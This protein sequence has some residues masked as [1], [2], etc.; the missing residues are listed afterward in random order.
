M[1]NHHEETL[2]RR[3]FLKAVAATAAAASVVGGGA[4]VLLNQQEAGTVVT[5]LADSPPLPVVGAARTAVDV[6]T[7]AA[8]LLARLAS[9]QAENLR[10]QAEL[11][12]SQL[13]LQA[14][15]ATSGDV[16]ATNEALQ[17]ELASANERV[18]LL[19]GLVALYE[20]LENV[21][22]AETVD[23]GLDSV[24][25]ALDDL[26]GEVPTLEEGLAIGEQALADFE[27]EIPLVRQG[28]LWLEG[29]LG[30]L[31]TF[32]EKAESLLGAVVA[33]AESFLQK[34]NEWFQGILKWLPFG[35]GDTAAE[36]MDALAD[37]LDETPNTIQGL[38]RHVADPLDVWVG[39]NGDEAPVRS[40]LIK[41]L[42]EKA[43]DP[44]GNVVGKTY[45]ARSAF[46]DQLVPQYQL[47]RKN[48]QAVKE[49]I[50]AYRKQHEI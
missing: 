48:T 3:G 18:G 31:T 19:A 35:V 25:M 4:A 2:N 30:R 45:A 15:E 32:Y 34:L 10:L 49:Q 44:A 5:T 22:L 11:R 20:Q 9:A 23:Q 21:D 12:A 40:K 42:K 7:E 8:D 38:R 50:A 27:A 43:L 33:S 24:G 37:L 28:R 16:G 36:I 29:H 13:R 6:N 26:F 41:P 47:A 14:L 1:A 39:T 46:E 17:L